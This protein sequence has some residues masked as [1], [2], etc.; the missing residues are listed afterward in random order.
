[1]ARDR[2]KYVTLYH[3][4]NLTEVEVDEDRAEVLKGRG[5]TTS[6][7]RAPRGRKGASRLEQMND[8]S[9][10]L[11]AEIDRLK[12]ENEALKSG[13]GEFPP[14]PAPEK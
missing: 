10:E 1:M 9:A 3:P 8:N 11:Q 7:P 2:T 14:P 4:E 5:Y 12:A 13:G 6:K